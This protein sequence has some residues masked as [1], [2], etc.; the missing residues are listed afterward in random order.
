MMARTRGAAR[1]ALAV[2]LVVAPIS[3]GAVPAAAQSFDCLIEPNASVSVAFPVE[4]LVETVT[5]DRGDLVKAGQVLA[6]LES[7]VERASVQLAKTRTELESAL[8]SNQVR[9]DF[10]VRRFVRTDDMYK[11]DLVPLKEL[12][13]A[14]TAKILAEIGVLEAKENQKLAELELERARAALEL[15]T[16]R[17]P[18]TGVVVERVV[19]P[20]DHTKQTPV[21]KLAQIDP[22]RVEVIVP[23]ARLG[24]I[25]VGMRADVTPEAPVNGVYPARVTVVDRVVDAASGTFGIRL[26]LP[27]PDYRLPA[28]LKCKVR[29][30]R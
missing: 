24:K 22:L 28:G 6:T 14:E 19:Q 2:L 11:K 16:L 7:S 27:N 12:D 5:V 18:V 23:V 25:A 4:G 10:G 20:G 21:L 30:P 17:S 15:R 26:E 1:L 9:M 29:F 3:G 8:K 13:E